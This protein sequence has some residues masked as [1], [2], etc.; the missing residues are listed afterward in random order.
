MTFKTNVSINALI[1]IVPKS[2]GV[3][4]KVI[5]ILF[6]WKNHRS[7]V[8]LFIFET[9]IED[10]VVQISKACDNPRQREGKD[11][12]LR[13]A[14]R[15]QGNKADSHEADRKDSDYH[16]RSD[17]TT[18]FEHRAHRF[19]KHIEN[20]GHRNDPQHLPADLQRFRISQK[21]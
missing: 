3:S 2:F 11:R 6:I 12:K 20:I 16:R 10:I 9:V 8:Y 4:L 15:E 21:Q 7:F 19:Y 1:C 14:H 5:P 17:Q 13:F 18:G